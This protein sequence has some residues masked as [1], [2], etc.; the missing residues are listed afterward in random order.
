MANPRPAIIEKLLK[1]AE[2]TVNPRTGNEV[3]VF[4]CEAHGPLL[5]V[6]G[7]PL[8]ATDI[9]CVECQTILAWVR[10]AYAQDDPD[11]H[12]THPSVEPLVRAVANAVQEHRAGNLDLDIYRHPKDMKVVLTDSIQ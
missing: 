9:H 3:C 4:R 6:A 5:N 1:N 8:A 7:E 2:Y 10:E 12:A 11:Y